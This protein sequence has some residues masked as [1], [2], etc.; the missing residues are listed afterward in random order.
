MLLTAQ[1]V[2]PAVRPNRIGL[3]GPANHLPLSSMLKRGSLENLSI[4]RES[5]AFVMQTLPIDTYFTT[6]C[7][8][9]S[10]GIGTPS[11]LFHLTASP[12]LLTLAFMHSM[13]ISAIRKEARC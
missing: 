1:S 10:I 3:V 4:G 11:V 7:S 6:P 8:I 5:E 2:C 9:E 12:S 13:T